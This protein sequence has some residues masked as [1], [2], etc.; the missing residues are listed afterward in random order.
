MITANSVL[1]GLKSDV[2]APGRQPA[3]SGEKSGASLFDNTL[4]NAGGR[5]KNQPADPGRAE[6]ARTPIREQ[7]GAEDRS[8][9]RETELAQHNRESAA[10]G[11]PAPG[12]ASA[13][14]TSPSAGAGNDT[15]A[16]EAGGALSMT[17]MT[18]ADIRQG[19][20]ELLAAAGKDASD[21]EI[22][23]I[24]EAL[25]VQAGEVGGAPES[26]DAALLAG[27]LSLLSENQ[28]MTDNSRGFPAGQ[29]AGFLEGNGDVKF[30]ALHPEAAGLQEGK[31]QLRQN[32]DSLRA[33]I[34]EGDTAGAR[35]GEMTGAKAEGGSEL[36]ANLKGLLAAL[37]NGSMKGRD[38][39]AEA[40]QTQVE[41]LLA[42]FENGSLKLQGA[43]S[44][45]SEDLRANLARLL[46]ALE[47][48]ALKGRGPETV[49]AGSD[50]GR[51]LRAQLERMFRSAENE[52]GPGV[53][54]KVA[55]E[56][57]PPVKPGVRAGSA[58]GG[59]NG[60]D[61]FPTAA[62]QSLRQLLNELAGQVKTSGSEK[63][64][65]GMAASQD[66][67]GHLQNVEQLLKNLTSEKMEGR[68]GAAKDSG[69][70]RAMET[71]GQTQST[72]QGSEK[73]EAAAAP[74]KQAAPGFD[75]ALQGAENRI[76]SQV[77]VRL[78]SGVRQGSGNMT[79][80]MHPP[81]L[82]SVKVRIVSDRGHLSVSLH[83]QNH[84]V[85]GIL[86]KHLPMLQQ[87]LADQDIDVSDLQVSVDS[88]GEEGQ[89]QFEDPAFRPPNPN[90]AVSADE[91]EPE[92]GSAVMPPAGTGR[93]QGLSLRV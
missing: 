75:R 16:P 12:K 61:G 78:F 57:V 21:P 3:G 30:L 14:G 88:G 8:R 13:A 42:S 5:D 46:R 9:C 10:N 64:D 26:G 92:P 85:V 38:T 84:Q 37:E 86:E 47:G 93:A 68:P 29:I 72:A 70:A 54:A 49:P 19:L 87:S 22:S 15:K 28:A 80:N 73:G 34:T 51:E 17:D 27:I 40:V 81:E 58:E 91:N 59:G 69:A 62:E 82:G 76:V 65:S 63:T 71:L 24:L 83:P 1:M 45:T 39:G 6:N 52:P 56:A 32:L 48:E 77:F 2:D 25:G 44:D 79:I 23:E 53:S 67:E 43:G 31:A 74:A 35:N 55:A 7:S 4:A 66:A 36:Q 11:K 60:R 89:P 20:Q 18:D 50:A 33:L 41:R 90:M